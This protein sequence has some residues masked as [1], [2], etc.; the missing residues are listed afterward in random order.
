MVRNRQLYYAMV[1]NLDYNV[2]RLMQHLR[3]TG[4]ADNTIVVVTADHG[5]FGGSHSLHEKQYPFEES[6]ACR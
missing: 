3:A 2:G 4:L 5:E 6:I 1:E